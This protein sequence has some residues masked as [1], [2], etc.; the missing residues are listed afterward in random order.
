MT[1][2]SRDEELPSFGYLLICIPA[3]LAVGAV[4]AY[5]LIALYGQANTLEGVIVFLVAGLI[6]LIVG[7]NG[8]STPAIFSRAELRWEVFVALGLFFTLAVKNLLFAI[9]TTGVSANLCYALSAMLAS[10][11][12]VSVT[13]IFLHSYWSAVFPPKVEQPE[14]AAS[15]V[16]ADLRAR[17]IDSSPVAQLEG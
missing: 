10:L 3:L 2:A 14:T 12:L 7:L 17:I 11:T 4:G 5:G 6:A 13:N 15:P 9:G 1:H 16:P 8:F